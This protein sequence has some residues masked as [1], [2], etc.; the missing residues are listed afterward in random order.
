M[1]N[2]CFSFYFTL[3]R[4]SLYTQFDCKVVDIVPSRLVYYNTNYLKVKFCD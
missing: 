4:P 2:F 1:H 3:I